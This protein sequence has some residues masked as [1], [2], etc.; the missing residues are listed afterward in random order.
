MTNEH[1]S[2]KKVLLSHLFSEMDMMPQT[3]AISAQS[4][5]HLTNEKS[6]N[7]FYNEQIVE[8]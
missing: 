5:M 6:Q 4:N 7:L 8:R 1:Q 3:S 2:Y